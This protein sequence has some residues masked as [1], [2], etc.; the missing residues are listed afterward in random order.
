MV[1]W[2]INS[3]PLGDRN[4]NDL[5]GGTPDQIGKAVNASRTRPKIIG[6]QWT[7]YA[8]I[9]ARFPSLRDK[10]WGAHERVSVK[11]ASAEEGKRMMQLRRRWMVLMVQPLS[12]SS[13]T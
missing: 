4:D 5:N 7:R 6:E 8:Y 3:I 2:S 11:R 13:S 10:T 1:S 9:V 12:Q